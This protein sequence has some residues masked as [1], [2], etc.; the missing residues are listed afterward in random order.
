[1]MNTNETLII[2]R[3]DI[4]LTQYRVEDPDKLVRV[5]RSFAKEGQISPILLIAN[6][7]DSYPN[8]RMRSDLPKMVIDKKVYAIA[9][10]NQKIFAIDAL[11]IENVMIKVY[12]NNAEMR[13]E[14]RKQNEW[15]N[16]QEKV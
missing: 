2:P 1:M 11:G 3:K 12:T 16:T 10:G 9:A 4:T 5:I 8:Y 6:P 13:E 14:R 15:Y 7:E